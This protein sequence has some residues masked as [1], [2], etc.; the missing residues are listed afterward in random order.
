MN[1]SQKQVLR[2]ALYEFMQRREP[3][4]EYVAKRYAA[5][6][7]NFRDGKLVQIPQ[8][9]AMAHAMLEDIDVLAECDIPVSPQGD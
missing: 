6:D 4:G 8:R 5:H 7:Q 2:D 9:I 3:V 1:D